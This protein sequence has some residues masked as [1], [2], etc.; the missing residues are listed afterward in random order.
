MQKCKAKDDSRCERL[1]PSALK[2]Y[3]TGSQATSSIEPHISKTTFKNIDVY[4]DI[5]I[6]IYIDENIDINDDIN[7]MR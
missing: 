3:C 1:T 5:D 7:Q 4:V 2:H 6:D